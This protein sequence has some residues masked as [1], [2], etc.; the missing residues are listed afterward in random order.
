MEPTKMRHLS[1]PEHPPFV[2]D[3]LSAVSN[4]PMQ[5]VVSFGIVTVILIAA[6]LTDFI[7]RSDGAAGFVDAQKTA[8]VAGV[9]ARR[10]ATSTWDKT[11]TLP[12]EK[13]RSYLPD[14]T[15]C[16]T[17]GPPARSLRQGEATRGSGESQPPSERR[18]L[19]FVS[20]MEGVCVK[21]F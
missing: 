6:A 5:F 10:P 14:A 18:D 8:S 20:E 13:K 9:T 2:S 11:F 12:P 1:N 3:R 19:F 15:A 21:N 4:V 16:A 17:A 7:P